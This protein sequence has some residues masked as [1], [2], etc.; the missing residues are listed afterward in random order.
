MISSTAAFSISHASVVGNSQLHTTTRPNWVQKVK[1]HHGL[2]RVGASF[3]RLPVVEREDQTDGSLVWQR[4][5]LNPPRQR[6]IDD[7]KLR[8]FSC[9]TIKAYVH[10]VERSARGGHRQPA[11]GDSDSSGQGGKKDRYAQ[12]SPWAFGSIRRLFGTTATQE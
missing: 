4:V 6:F 8:N 12:L 9:G 11:D 2:L 5:L 1:T 7:L 10:A 3:L